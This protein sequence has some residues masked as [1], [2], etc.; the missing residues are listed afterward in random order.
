MKAPL[1]I[2]LDS[3]VGPVGTMVVSPSRTPGTVNIQRRQRR[4]D[5]T[6]NKPAC[7]AFAF[8]DAA[9]TN[10]SP[11]RKRLWCSA[12]RN[13]QLS[14]YDLWMSHSIPCLAAGWLPPAI[15]P[16]PGGFRGGPAPP[17]PFWID[18]PHAKL[19]SNQTAYGTV[20][21]DYYY[22]APHY[23]TLTI[24]LDLRHP[25]DNN[26]FTLDFSS[27]LLYNND[28]DAW[29]HTQ[30]QTRVDNNYSLEVALGPFPDIIPPTS[31]GV[32]ELAYANL[33]QRFVI[34][35]G[36]VMN[37]PLDPCSAD[38]PAMAMTAHSEDVLLPGMQEFWRPPDLSASFLSASCD[39]STPQRGR[40]RRL[41]PQPLLRDYH[42]RNV[43]M[44]NF[45]IV[46]HWRPRRNNYHWDYHC[47]KYEYAP[48][49]LYYPPPYD[50]EPNGRTIILYHG[51]LF[52]FLWADNR[53]RSMTMTDPIKAPEKP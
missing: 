25:D 40:C 9:Y 19:R 45:H 30:V 52:S 16:T 29:S 33:R 15:P 6:H 37:L 3:A 32:I 7:K 35:A 34:N 50:Y 28:A 39:A 43:D 22:H 49:T 31:V 26:P 11:C 24:N 4:T 20:A 18:Y 47:W 23:I 46:G 27:W 12:Q 14:G 48:A 44:A 1:S 21:W 42:D 17:G 36:R 38:T 8:L 41:S 51:T 10:M 5:S 2:L 53:K 13:P